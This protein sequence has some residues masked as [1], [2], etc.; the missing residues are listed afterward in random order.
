MQRENKT[1]VSDFRQAFIT[2]GFAWQQFFKVPCADESW[3]R[4]WL[5]LYDLRTLLAAF[6][7]LSEGSWH[8]TRQLCF[9]IAAT[10]K[11]VKYE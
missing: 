1:H 11:T 7:F 2:L 4:S 5:R 10:L 8:T 6:E 3:I 9:E